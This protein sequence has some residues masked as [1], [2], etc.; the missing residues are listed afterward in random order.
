MLR[1]HA[2]RQV[3]LLQILIAFLFARK[4]LLN[5]LQALN[6]L[7]A[8]PVLHQDFRLQ[9]QILQGGGAQRRALGFG[10]LGRL[11]HA[12]E[13]RRNHPEAVLVDFSAQ[14][15]QA[16]LMAGLVGIHIGGAIQALRGLG[17][18]SHAAVQIEEL[19]Q[20]LA[21]VPFAVGGS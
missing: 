1:T 13:A 12:G 6:R 7:G 20:S 4:K 10:R 11:G 8:H 9:H 17:V 5:A 16:L 19:E 15:F 2:R 18:I 3:Q 21:I 14:H